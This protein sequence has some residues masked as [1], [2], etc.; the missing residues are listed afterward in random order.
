MIFKKSVPIFYSE[1][2]SRSIDY[3]SQVL[4]FEH[5]WKYDDPPTFGGVSKDL[6]EIFFCKDGQ[7][8]P[9]TWM[10]IFVD[11]VDEYYETVKVKGAIIRSTPE[12]MEWGV[13]EML[14]EDPDKHILRFGHGISHN[15]QKSGALPDG[16]QIIDRVPTVQEYQELVAA[17]KWD[18]KEERITQKLIS[19]V[20]FAAVAVD[21]GGTV[22]GCALVIGDGASFYYIKD[23]MV[24][25]KYQSKRVG[26]ALMQRINDWINI[27]GEADPLVGLYTGQH[28]APFY[29]QF[30]FREYFGMSR[31]VRK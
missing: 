17:V 3:Y 4:C 9:G 26:T 15:R 12:D 16:T 31:F 27:H 1:D 10:S 11:N 2:V 23:M 25:P 7:G 19:S 6:V 30:G 29:R 21:P 14:V 28:L 8:C 20:L 22:V 5:H 24:D 13:R 18:Q